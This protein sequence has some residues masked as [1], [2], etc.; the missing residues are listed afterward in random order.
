[1]RML[2][3]PSFCRFLNKGVFASIVHKA[4]PF[5]PKIDL[6]TKLSHDTQPKSILSNTHKLTEYK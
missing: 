1:M 4:S 3:Y 2:I 5:C 6:D